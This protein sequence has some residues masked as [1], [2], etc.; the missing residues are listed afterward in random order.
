MA[1]RARKA[2]VAIRCETRELARV[3][4]VP[5]CVKGAFFSF[6]YRRRLAFCF[7]TG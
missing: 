1:G 6:C 3:A 5:L 7:D 2:E 4:H